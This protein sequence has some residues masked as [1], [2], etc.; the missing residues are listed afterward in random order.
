MIDIGAKDRSEAMTA[1]QLGDTAI[2]DS[3]FEAGQGHIMGRALDDRAGCARPH[4]PVRAG[5]AV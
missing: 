1:V 2:F 3:F 4:S 5:L